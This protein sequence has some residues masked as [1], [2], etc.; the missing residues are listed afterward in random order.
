MTEVAPQDAPEIQED[1]P[2]PAPLPWAEVSAEHF[3]MLRLAPLPTDRNS[4]ARPLRFVQYGFAERHGKDLSLLR[5]TIQL[6]GQKVRKEQNHLDI[7]VDHLEKH[8]RIGPD[9]GL[10]VEPLNRGLGRFLLAQ[11]ISWA[12]RKWSHYRVEG[13]ALASKDALNEDTRLRRDQLLRSHGLEVEYADAQHLKGRYVDVQVG[14]LK[15]GWNTE[16]VQRVEIL[17]AA[18]MLQQAEQS[19]QEK[20]AQLRERDER[21]SKYRRE[22]SGLRFTI[23]CLVAFAVFQAGLLIWIAT[24]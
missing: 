8:V 19:L 17:E 11:A 14:E 21:V 13:A 10:Q 6:P 9:S 4:G 20:E 1:A 7:W 12:Q 15:G 5:M 2:E 16:K 3:Q 23:T 18:Q 24:H 22:D